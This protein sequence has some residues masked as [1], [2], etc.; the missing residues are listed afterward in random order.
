MWPLLVTNTPEMRTVQIGISM[1]QFS[2]GIVFGL[3][4]AGCMLILL[5]SIIFFIIC[6]KKMANSLT[7]G[8]V[9]G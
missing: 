7:V 6:R 3:V 4:N 8:A 5:P 2:E 9:K 1:L